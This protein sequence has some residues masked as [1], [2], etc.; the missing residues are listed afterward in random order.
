[1]DDRSPISPAYLGTKTVAKTEMLTCVMLLL[2][3]CSFYR[4]SLPL[5]VHIPVPPDHWQAIYSEA[6]FRIVYPTSDNGEFEQR[7]VDGQ[8]PVSIELPKVI[9]LP[10]LAY[11]ILAAQSVELPAAGGVYPLDCSIS[12]NTISLCWQQGAVAEVLFRLWSQGVDCS[13][14]NVSRLRRE[15]TS[16]CLGDPWAG[17]PW[18]LDLDRICEKLAAEEFRLTDIRPIPHR[19]LKLEPGPGQWFLESPFRQP[20]QAEADGVLLL[21]AV[22]FGA[23]FLFESSAGACL[24]LYVEKKNVLLS[25]R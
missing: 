15:M 19:D 20:V 8:A 1:M 21:E 2:Y 13:V 4:P 16:R 14:V 23:H 11:P 5:T 7:L 9:N 12:G 18:A 17:D 3:A 10:I 6:T 24:F 22:P 25:P